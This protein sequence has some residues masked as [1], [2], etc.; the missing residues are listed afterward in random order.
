MLASRLSKKIEEYLGQYIVQTNK[1]DVSLSGQIEMVDLQLKES[2]IPN[3]A[4]RV[5]GGS[6]RRL[7]VKVPWKHL[8]SKSTEAVVDDITVILGIRTVKQGDRAL[9]YESAV[10]SKAEAVK[11]STKDKGRIASLVNTI[12][13]NLVLNVHHPAH[14]H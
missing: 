6:I 7:S 3:T 4:L 8:S 5:K 14:P 1:V 12:V 9:Q 10:K 2:D 13:D 11:R